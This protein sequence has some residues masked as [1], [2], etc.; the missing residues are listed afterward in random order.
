MLDGNLLKSPEKPGTKIYLDSHHREGIM[1]VMR[2][3]GI[4]NTKI[5]VAGFEHE[6][7]KKPDP[8]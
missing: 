5:Y 7:N 3:G 6:I 1:K 2:G 4:C 8:G